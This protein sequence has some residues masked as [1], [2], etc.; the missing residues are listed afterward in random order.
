MLGIVIA[1][2]V[3]LAYIAFGVGVIRWDR[4]QRRRAQF[5]AAVERACAQ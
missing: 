5:T 3:G 4:R 2:F 1:A